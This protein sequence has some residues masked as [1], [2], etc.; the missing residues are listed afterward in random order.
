[1]PGASHP[2]VT[3]D[4]RPGRILLAEQ[5]VMSVQGSHHSYI[6]D[7]V[8]HPNA[9]VHPPGPPQ[10]R[11]VARNK[12]AAPVA[13]QRLVRPLARPRRRRPEQILCLSI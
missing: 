9:Q 3:S 6:S 2:A 8:S 5:Q 4:A 13:V 1:V 12:N 10:R 11:G 7:L